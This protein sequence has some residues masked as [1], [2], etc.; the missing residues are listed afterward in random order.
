MSNSELPVGKSQTYLWK[1]K[2]WI[3]DSISHQKGVRED[4]FIDG[5]LDESD[6]PEALN[7]TG[8]YKCKGRKY[9]PTIDEGSRRE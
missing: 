7:R 6:R 1:Y 8:D 5:N 9:V 4:S 2:A 3:T